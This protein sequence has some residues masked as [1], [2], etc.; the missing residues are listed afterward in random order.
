MSIL[1]DL[2]NKVG[3]IKNKIK[4]HKDYRTSVLND[5]SCVR[6]AFFQVY[7]ASGHKTFPG[8]TSDRI[9]NVGFDPIEIFPV[10]INPN[11]ISLDYYDSNKLSKATDASIYAGGPASIPLR[12]DNRGDINPGSVDLTL[13]YDIYDEYNART[14]NGSIPENEISLH[15]DSNNSPI[16][17]LQK[18]RQYAGNT[19]RYFV[20]FTWG[21][22]HVFGLLSSLDITYE[23]F[24]RWGNP[25]SATTR[26]TINRQPLAYDSDGIE[27][28]PFDCPQLQTGTVQA[29]AYRKYH[30]TAMRVQLTASNAL[31]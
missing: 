7:Q 30:D 31:R 23:S 19:G 8:K 29:G 20:L 4:S 1:T 21:E 13:R 25:L 22:I 14:M 27:Q 11:S 15:S 12:Y 3:K 9:L 24:S 10:Q 26:V 17:S 18:L 6:K 2:T 28:D 5:F 16:T